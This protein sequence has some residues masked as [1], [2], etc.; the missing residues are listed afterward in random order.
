MP[1]TAPIKNVTTPYKFNGTVV[2]E[3][4]GGA[5]AHISVVSVSVSEE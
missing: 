5:F 3:I 1:T 4:F 2:T